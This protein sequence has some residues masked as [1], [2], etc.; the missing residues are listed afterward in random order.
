MLVVASCCLLGSVDGRSRL[1]G[2][3]LSDTPIR[4]PEI[5]KNSAKTRRESQKPQFS[6]LSRWKM[7]RYAQTE[8]TDRSWRLKERAT[9][10]CQ[11]SCCLARLRRHNVRRNVD[12]SRSCSLKC[13]NVVAVLF[14]FD[15]G[16]SNEPCSRRNVH[17]VALARQF[18]H[19]A[20][21]HLPADCCI[22]SC[23][24]SLGRRLRRN[25]VKPPN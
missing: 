21:H 25:H 18:G 14:L 10:F 7:L 4:N 16:K 13:S 9:C 8:G 20:S 2:S 1:Q 19:I 12:G 24:F 15:V 5:R 22:L 3:G 11:A 23:L 17:P 6:V